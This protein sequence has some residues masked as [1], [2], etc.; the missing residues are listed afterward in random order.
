[1]STSRSST[2]SIASSAA[3]GQLDAD[4]SIVLFGIE[5]DL[6]WPEGQLD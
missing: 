1:V 2:T 5:L 6:D 4:E 3:T